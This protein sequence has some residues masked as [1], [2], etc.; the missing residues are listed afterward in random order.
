MKKLLLICIISLYGC[1]KEISY[2]IEKSGSPYKKSVSCTFSGFCFGLGYRGKYT[3]K[4][5]NFCN[6]KQLALVQDYTRISYKESGK[7]KRGKEYK[8]I[9]IITQCK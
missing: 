8:T 9:K 1:D 3:T 7:I 2:T 6:G 4:F 5:S